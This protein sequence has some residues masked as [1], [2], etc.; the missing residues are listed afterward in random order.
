[1]FVHWHGKPTSALYST[2]GNPTFDSSIKKFGTHSLY[3][4]NTDSTIYDLVNYDCNLPSSRPWTVEFWTY[5]AVNG[6]P[7]S[8]NDEYTI[9]STPASST[10]NG[11]FIGTAAQTATAF[12]FS[13]AFNGLGVGYIESGPDFNEN[14]WIHVVLQRSSAAVFSLYIDGT[15]ATNAASVGDDLSNTFK[16]GSD[17]ATNDDDGW[18]VYID[19]LRVSNITRYS[20]SSFTVPTTEFTPD[21]NT[22][23]LAH[24]N[25]SY[26]NSI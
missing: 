20:G 8:G 23:F 10:S 19:E 5:V 6:Y 21:A 1:M 2:V 15:L 7:D 25:N 12:K 13:A 24:F 17:Y 18:A 11:V 3:L 4:T 22:V 14:N 26:E 9:F 16:L